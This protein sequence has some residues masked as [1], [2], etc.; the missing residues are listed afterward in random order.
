MIAGPTASGKS[1]LAVRL[2]SH[3]DGAVL[4]TDALQVYDGLRIL[5][6]RPRE[7]EMGNVAHHLYGHV[8]PHKPYSVGEWRRDVEATLSALPPQTIPV[9]CGGTGLY[10]RA[11]LMGLDDFPT[12]PE[13][14]RS[15][16]RN[17]GETTAVASLHAELVRRDPDAALTIRPTDRQRIVRA[18]E[19]IDTTTRPLAELRTNLTGGLFDPARVMAIVLVPPRNELRE[20][21]AQRFHAM[22]A[23]G[24]LDEAVE[25]RER[26]GDGAPLAE[27]AIGLR[28][29][30]GV[31]NGT[32]SLEQA[33]ESAI[34]RSRQYAKRQETWFRNQFGPTWSRYASP[35]DVPVG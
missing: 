7:S 34:T 25:F 18:L 20:R 8:S 11:L 3:F 23:D 19:L 32:S 21:I 10:F 6:A 17:L 27:K 30:L 28:E 14:I 24:A 13:P 33:A 9:F 1:A 26:F 12:V 5:T 29:L 22:L 16:W 2:A 4:N 35:L 31:A 15:Y